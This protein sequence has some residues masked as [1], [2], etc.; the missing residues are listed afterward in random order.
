L[1]NP[2]VSNPRCF[3]WGQLE[4]APKPE[5][6]YL[7]FQQPPITYNEEE[8]IELARQGKTE[9]AQ[10]LLKQAGKTE[11]DLEANP[12][13]RDTLEHSERLHIQSKKLGGGI[14]VSRPITNF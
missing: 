6:D 14:H 5:Q 3:I 8:L 2:K 11:S 7:A 13:F 1:N 4:E 10:Q 12:A 9:N